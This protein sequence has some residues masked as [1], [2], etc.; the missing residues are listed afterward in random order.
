MKG[1]NCGRGQVHFMEVTTARLYAGWEHSPGQALSPPL[2]GVLPVGGREG[3]RGL[4]GGG[5]DRTPWLRL[6]LQPVP[7]RRPAPARAQ[8]RGWK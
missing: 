8:G 2:Q 6:R 5:S 1:G 3:L 7:R 4:T